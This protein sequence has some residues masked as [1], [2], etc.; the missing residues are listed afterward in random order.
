[1]QRQMSAFSV[2]G[3][4]DDAGG[5]EDLPFDES[6]M[7]GALSTLAGEA[8]ALDED[9]P[10]AAA[11]LMRKLSKMTGMEYGGAMQ[12]ALSRM[13]SGEDPDQ[14]EAEL[15]DALEAEAP[16]FASGTPARVRARGGRP[17]ERDET[18]YE[19]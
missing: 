8:G 11:R 14:I 12:E 13:E 4:S 16:C 6:R 18:L 7:E 9:D 5:G 15:G 17:P 10:R 19:M 3:R 2:T 1:M